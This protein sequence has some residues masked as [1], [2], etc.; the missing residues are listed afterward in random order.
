MDPKLA[1]RFARL[2]EQEEKGET[3]VGEIGSAAPK[4]QVLDPVLAA[5]W[6]KQQDGAGDTI[7][8][9]VQKNVDTAKQSAKPW[10][11][12][13]GNSELEKRWAKQ[14]DRTE[15]EAKQLEESL[16][17]G[18][19]DWKGSMASELAGKLAS[20]QKFP[21]EDECNHLGCGT[22]QSGEKICDAAER[23]NLA[24][25]AG[26]AVTHTLVWPASGLA[27]TIQWNGVCLDEFDIDLE[28]TVALCVGSE[29]TTINIHRN[30]RGT[31]FWGS[32]TPTRD[33]RVAALKKVC[34]NGT[35]QA[36]DVIS[37]EVKE[38]MFRFSNSFSWFN[39]KSVE[40]V[41]LLT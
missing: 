40:F 30:A 34:T 8:D 17:G 19:K 7:E 22:D 6:A 12:R 16:E 37:I 18:K 39:A 29:D 27:E 23:N 32:F 35:S 21:E 5:R 10:E 11:S 3:D 24:V 15:E 28:I 20:R 25:P 36:H 4:K 9:L 41:T 2:K 13:Q 1:A 14:Q 38:I 31:N 33:R 26:R